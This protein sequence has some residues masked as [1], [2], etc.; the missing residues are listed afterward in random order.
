MLQL[1]GPGAVPNSVDNP[2][3]ATRDAPCVQHCIV[4]YWNTEAAYPW[5]LQ[6]GVA[7]TLPQLSAD[8][9][10][11]RRSTEGPA[12][13][14]HN[15]EGPAA[16]ASSTTI[17]HTH[18]SASSDNLKSKSG[19][20]RSRKAKSQ[21][22]V[23]VHSETAGSHEPTAL[24]TVEQEQELTESPSA[25]FVLYATSTWLPADPLLS[26]FKVPES[27]MMQVAD[28]HDGSS[29]GPAQ[30]TS[31]PL[32]AQS[33]GKRPA[34][35][36][37]HSLCAAELASAPASVFMFVAAIMSCQQFAAQLQSP[38]AS[39][40]NRCITPRTHVHVQCLCAPVAWHI[41]LKMRSCL[42]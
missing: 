20:S 23:P 16:S 42:H 31:E 30:P 13:P 8:P 24:D 40:S 2:S 39:I 17:T 4:S 41:R 3:Y 35:V 14:Q 26:T 22:S 29:G 33:D 7:P 5:A 19:R 21:K 10:A 11:P 15:A 25:D 34:R 37:S 9:A 1:S 32:A 12:A 38:E 27:H 36:S 6:I 18:K 28:H